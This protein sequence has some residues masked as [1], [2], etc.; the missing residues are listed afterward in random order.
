MLGEVPARRSFSVRF[1]SYVRRV[2]QRSLSRSRSW[3]FSRPVSCR[4]RGS[5]CHAVI[6]RC[7]TARRVFRVVVTVA[8]LSASL[9]ESAGA[10][11]DA[12]L[13]SRRHTALMRHVV[14]TGEQ[15][16]GEPDAAAGPR[17]KQRGGPRGD[18]DGYYSSW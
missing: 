4:E 15:L 11:C 1:F 5:A 3:F 2:S 17:G 6:A 18:D 7:R 13:V 10:V 16:D 8:G 14:S 9:V 12:L